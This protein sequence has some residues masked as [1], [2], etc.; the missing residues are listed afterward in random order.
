MARKSARGSLGGWTKGVQQPVLD[1]LSPRGSSTH[2]RPHSESRSVKIS[3]N[4]RA[5]VLDQLADGGKTLFQLEC[6]LVYRRPELVSAL[7]DLIRGGRVVAIQTGQ[8][9]IYQL[10]L[11]SLEEWISNDW[12]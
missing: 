9:K 4:I 7:A 12:V 5:Q 3:A 6:A 8:T 2:A 10:L 1:P 11:L